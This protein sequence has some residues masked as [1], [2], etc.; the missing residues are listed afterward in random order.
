MNGEKSPLQR[1]VIAR[2]ESEREKEREGGKRKILRKLVLTHHKSDRK[3]IDIGSG[4]SNK[5][6]PCLNCIL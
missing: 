1:K 4:V 2:R 3:P 6:F 5:R